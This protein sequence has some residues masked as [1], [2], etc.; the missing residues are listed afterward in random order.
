MSNSDTADITE[1][2]Q[3]KI[4]YTFAA[5][6]HNLNVLLS[7]NLYLRD[8][9]T[10]GQ[11][12]GIEFG[13]SVTSGGN[14]FNEFPDNWPNFAY[15]WVDPRFYPPSLKFLKF[16]FLNWSIAVYSPIGWTPV[17][18]TTEKETNERTNGRTD[19]RTERHVAS[20]GPSVCPSLRRSLTL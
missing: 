3:K 13:G 9:R 19:G 20:L 5:R 18:D 2:K 7:V 10:D 4:N 14:N 12:P 8:G 17:T 6:R 16:L 1:L 11:T 15:L